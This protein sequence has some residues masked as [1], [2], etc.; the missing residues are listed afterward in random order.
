MIILWKEGWACLFKSFSELSESDIEKEIFIRNQKH[1]VAEAIFRQL[2]N[3]AYHFGHIIFAGK[4]VSTSSWLSLSISKGNSKV[5]NIGMY[6]QPKETRPMTEYFC[7]GKNEKASF[8]H[9][10][11]Y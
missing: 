4:M 11:G 9:S 2:A 5:H 7:R 8:S 1:S 6:T 10:I 3:Y